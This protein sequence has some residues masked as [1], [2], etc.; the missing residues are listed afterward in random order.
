M[1]KKSQKQPKR[2]QVIQQK[3]AIYV[4]LFSFWYFESKD[5]PFLTKQ[6]FDVTLVSYD[7][8][9]FPAPKTVLSAASKIFNSIL[10]ISIS[11]QHTC[12]Y[13]KYVMVEELDALS[14]YIYLIFVKI[15][16]YILSLMSIYNIVTENITFFVQRQFN[17]EK[18][19]F[20]FYYELHAPNHFSIYLSIYFE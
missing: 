4:K 8:I 15:E 7:L 6:F 3:V 1:S 9:I 12:S 17:Q 10:T 19:P 5:N 11:D 13:L 18:N 14:Q 2:F 16:L 20:S